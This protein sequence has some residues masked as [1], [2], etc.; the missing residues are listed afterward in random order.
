MFDRI[1]TSEECRRQLSSLSGQINA[2]YVLWNRKAGLP[3]YVGTAK[4]PGRL[5]AHLKKD[6]PGEEQTGHLKGNAPFHAYVKSQEQGWLGL[7]FVLYA[8]EEEAKSAERALIAN[9]GLRSSGGQLFNR[10]MGG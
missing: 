2:C 1:L 4:T 10:R 3:V 9:H 6:R 7:S 8:T 5:R